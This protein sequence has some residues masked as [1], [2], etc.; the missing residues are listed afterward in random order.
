MRSRIGAKATAHLSRGSTIGIFLM[1]FLAVVREGTE[2]VLFLQ[3]SVLHS[4][5][6]FQEI[7]AIAGIVFALGLSFLMFRG[8][9][10]LPLKWIFRVTNALLILFAA[11]LLAHGLHEF[12]EASLITWGSQILWDINPPML[13][14]GV[15]P[16]LHDHGAIG[17][18]LRALIGYN[19][20][21][22]ALEVGAYVAY[23]LCVFGSF[24]IM[25]RNN[26]TY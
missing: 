18:T 11:G 3:A 2:T 10:A 24:K 8:I 20:D 1:S 5:E 26:I 4:R 25:Q 15:Y 19:G 12:Q 16:L 21:P 7:G 22:T 9:H 17:G 23:L 13:V 14:D 6:M